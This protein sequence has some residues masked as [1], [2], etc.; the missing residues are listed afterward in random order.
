MI[1]VKKV[2]FFW[3]KHMLCFFSWSKQIVSNDR[4]KVY[5]FYIM[6]KNGLTFL[7]CTNYCATCKS[8]QT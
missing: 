5:L 3:C 2:D 6:Q 4:Q 8:K 1:L 7:Q